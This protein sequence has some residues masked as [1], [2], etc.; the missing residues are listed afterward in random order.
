MTPEEVAKRWRCSKDAVYDMLARGDLPGFK[1]GRSWRIT[2]QAV[3]DYEC[4]PSE[5]THYKT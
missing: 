2:A 3:H 4:T 1:V 5:A